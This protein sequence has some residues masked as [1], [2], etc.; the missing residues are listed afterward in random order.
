MIFPQ[1]L[2]TERLVLRCPLPNDGAAIN[3]AIQETWNDLN[4][5]LDWA[6]E[7][8]TV[9]QSEA[10][11][12]EAHEKFHAGEDFYLRGFLRDEQSTFVLAARLHPRDCSVPCFEIGYW[13]RASMQGQ[14]FVT[15]AVRAIAQTAFSVMNAERLEIHCDA[16][17]KNSIRVAQRCGFHQEAHLH[18]HK[19]ALDGTLRDTLIFARLRNQV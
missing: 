18:H 5:W 17:N 16:R 7:I 3:A 11:S 2:Q 8:P 9:G 19:R 13:C 6:Q 12:L 10:K 4:C 14:G 1:I 15:E